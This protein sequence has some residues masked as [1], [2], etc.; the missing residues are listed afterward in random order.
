MKIAVVAYPSL[1]D[2]D[3]EWIEAIRQHHDPQAARIAAH[4]TFVFPIEAEPR[5]VLDH[6]SAVLARCRPIPLV[7][8][9][10]VALR[11]RIAGGAHVFLVPEEGCQELAHVH[12]RLYEGPLR[13][14]LRNDVPFLS[15]VT[16]A[17]GADGG[18]CERLA[19]Q[20]NRAGFAVRG[21]VRRVD[22]IA[23]G[24]D[25]VS[26]LATYELEPF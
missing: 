5:V 9:R 11:D 23:I 15:H 20:L 25:G 7:L 19:D 4:F 21:E 3:R 26:S 6:A 17:G 8:R 13:L 24:G 18:D 14:Y 2:A 16:V 1:E 10:A 22:V 12:D